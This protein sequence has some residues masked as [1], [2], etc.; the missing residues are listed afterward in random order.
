[1]KHRKRKVGKGT[2][3]KEREQTEHRRNEKLE[4]DKRTDRRET[5][6]NWTGTEHRYT[7]M[8][9]RAGHRDVKKWEQ[10]TEKAKKKDWESAQFEILVIVAVPGRPLQQHR[11]RG[12]PSCHNCFLWQLY[13]LISPVPGRQG[14]LLSILLRCKTCRPALPCQRHCLSVIFKF[15]LSA[16]R[17]DGHACWPLFGLIFWLR[18][19]VLYNF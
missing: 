10:G 5:K 6:E 15:I 9:D 19:H 13:I 17:I 7:A 18:V 4:K 2:D 3:F 16:S 8:L 12:A 1:M 11:P 14:F